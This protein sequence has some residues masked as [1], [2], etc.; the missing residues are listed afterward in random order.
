MHEIRNLFRN[1]KILK[2]TFWQQLVTH[3]F[4]LWRH[5]TLRLSL[6][7]IKSL[8]IGQNCSDNPCLLLAEILSKIRHAD[9]LVS[10]YLDPNVSPL[11]RSR[12]VEGELRTSFQPLF[13]TQILSSL[14]SLPDIFAV[15]F[16]STISDKISFRYFPH[17]N[18]FHAPISLNYRQ[19]MTPIKGDS[20]WLT[21]KDKL[22]LNW[23]C[24]S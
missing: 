14:F 13:H 16:P 11:F 2:L 9:W 10:A 4:C 17:Q 3:Y 18:Y 7:E 5:R 12:N 21:N 23:P 6:E 24:C 15:P 22:M 1:R 8:L 19:K 20:F